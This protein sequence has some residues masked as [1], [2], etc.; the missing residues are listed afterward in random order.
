MPFCSSGIIIINKESGCTSRDVVNEV[1]HILGTKKIGHTGTLDPMATGVLVLVVGRYTK[2]CNYL[3]SKFKEYIAT[4]RL[5]Y[6]SDTLDIT[7]TIKSHQTNIDEEKIK[8]SFNTFP[9]TYNQTVPIFS[10]VHVDG[11]RLYE[12]ARNNEEIKL[13]SREVTIDNLEILSIKNNEITFKCL[14]SKGT[15]I[16]SL[17]KDL[18]DSMNEHA[19]MSALNR[20]KQ[21]IFDI[22]DAVTI[23]EIKKGNIKL[24]T[25]KDIFDGTIINLDDIE[26]KKI[27]NGVK[28]KSN[29]NDQYILLLYKDKE[30]A[31]YKK[32]KDEYKMDVL[33]DI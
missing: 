25:L 32:D 9:R 30:V 24:I 11:K 7:G 6:S 20:T 21:G 15:Y 22:K 16:R 19:I 10:S 28:Y 31:L 3:T 33:L 18:G 23:D 29:C 26:Y 8:E 2:L 27:K 4:M 13:P 17:I 14:V 12:Y 5:G 1:S